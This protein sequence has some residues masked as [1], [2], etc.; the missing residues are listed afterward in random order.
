MQRIITV[1]EE[2][3]ASE[4][5]FELDKYLHTD[6]GRRHFNYCYLELKK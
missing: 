5:K 2:V 3:E 4:Q 1:R 6:K